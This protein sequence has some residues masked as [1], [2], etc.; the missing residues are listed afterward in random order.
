LKHSRGRPTTERPSGRAD[1]D[2][3]HWHVGRVDEAKSVLALR[4]SGHLAEV[5]HTASVPDPAPLAGASGSGDRG[6]RVAAV[7]KAKGHLQL[8]VIRCFTT[9]PSLKVHWNS[10]V[11]TGYEAAVPKSQTEQRSDQHCLPEV[12]KGPRAPEVL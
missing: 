9:Q 10:V 11:V 5:V 2:D 1:R 7:T 6:N 8:L 4:A 3:L 12:R